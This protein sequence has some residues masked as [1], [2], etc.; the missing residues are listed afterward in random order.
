MTENK[1][2]TKQ[3]EQLFSLHLNTTLEKLTDE[4]IKLLKEKCFEYSKR[5]EIDFKSTFEYFI[6][7]H[8]AKGNKFKNWFSAYKNWCRKSKQFEKNGNKNDYFNLGGN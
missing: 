5:N 1:P 8:K 6:D 7:Y 4:Y 3:K 2:Q